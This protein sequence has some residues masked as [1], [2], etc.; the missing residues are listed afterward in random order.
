MTTTLTFVSITPLQALGISNAFLMNLSVSDF[1]VGVWNMPITVIS[2]AANKWLLGN[3][4]CNF[5]GEIHY[6]DINIR[7]LNKFFCV[8]D[9][10]FFDSFFFM[11]PSF[12]TISKSK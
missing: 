1:V 11:L 7:H 5:S 10:S 8:Y 3:A 6:N 9:M 4:L 2:V 12:S